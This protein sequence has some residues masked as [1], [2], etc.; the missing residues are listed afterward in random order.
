M[1]INCRL[2]GKNKE[3]GFTLF[4]SSS[5]ETAQHT[6]RSAFAYP[7]LLGVTESAE[8]TG[9]FLGN[10]LSPELRLVVLEERY[11]LRSTREKRNYPVVLNK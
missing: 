4:H 6:T 2:S 9:I 1:P 5:P 11:T 3:H 7:P 10:S 8:I